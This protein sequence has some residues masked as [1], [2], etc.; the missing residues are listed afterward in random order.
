MNIG[1][2]E[3]DLLR[4][5]VIGAEHIEECASRQ[6]ADSEF[7]CAIQEFAFGYLSVSVEIVEVEKFLI[8]VFC[9]HAI[10]RIS[11]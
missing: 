10:H 5:C 2:V 8:K 1:V 3:G 11:P 4:Q 9:S 6:A 7:T